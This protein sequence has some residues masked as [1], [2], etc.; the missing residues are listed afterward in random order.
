[1]EEFESD[2][3]EEETE[4]STPKVGGWGTR[5]IVISLEPLPEYEN[6][7]IDK[8][9]DNSIFSVL[10]H[11]YYLMYQQNYVRARDPAWRKLDI[12]DDT[13]LGTAN[14]I[15]ALREVQTTK[16]VCGLRAD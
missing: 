16:E 6:P 10:N 8:I 14:L 11:D 3:V 4:E 13:N 5:G 2:E 12:W 9:Y 7:I 1:M 15:I